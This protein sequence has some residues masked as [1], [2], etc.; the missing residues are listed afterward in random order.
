MKL[1]E[2][3]CRLIPE[4]TE[5]QKKHM[6]TKESCDREIY[7]LQGEMQKILIADY[8]DEDTKRDILYSYSKSISQI[9]KQR[10]KCVW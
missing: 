3:I 5:E 9:R 4:P 6:I 1:I 2:F 7:R 10:R 8:L